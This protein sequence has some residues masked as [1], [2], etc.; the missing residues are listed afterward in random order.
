MWPVQPEWSP[1]AYRRLRKTPGSAAYL[2]TLSTSVGHIYL[3]SH[4]R[5]WYVSPSTTVVWSGTV[6]AAVNG[7]YGY[8]IGGGGTSKVL[9]I[10]TSDPAARARASG[11]ATEGGGWVGGFHTGGVRK[12]LLGAVHAGVCGRER[13]EPRRSDGLPAGVAHTV[14]AFVDANKRRAEAGNLVPALHIELGE[15][16]LVAEQGRPIRPLFGELVRVAEAVLHPRLPA[17]GGFE[18]LQEAGAERG[19]ARRV[20]M[21]GHRDSSSAPSCKLRAGRSSG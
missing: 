8:G 21:V 3:C 11:C 15:P 18:A 19:A 17:E 9:P 4:G 1:D 10:Y 12:P 6:Y 5:N 2:D 13:R 14:G 16:L 7:T 20:G